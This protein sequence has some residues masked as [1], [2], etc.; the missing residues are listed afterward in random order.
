MQQNVHVASLN[1]AE[2]LSFTPAT[3]LLKYSIAI[4]EKLIAEMMIPGIVL[5]GASRTT[6]P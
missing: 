4:T 5:L 2:L 1:T 3:V 6:S